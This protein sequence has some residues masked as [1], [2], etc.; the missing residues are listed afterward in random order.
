MQIGKTD[1]GFFYEL[2]LLFVMPLNMLSFD[3]HS[4]VNHTVISL[5]KHTFT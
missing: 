2:T 4:Y 3:T 5:W 1:T